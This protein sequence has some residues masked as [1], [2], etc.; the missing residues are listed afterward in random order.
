MH[1]EYQEKLALGSN[2]SFSRNYFRNPGSQHLL[3]GFH[4]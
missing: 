3:Q 4:F 1:V 2:R